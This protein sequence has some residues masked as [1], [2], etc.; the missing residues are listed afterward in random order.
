[1][2]KNFLL[3][4][5]LPSGNT[6][7]LVTEDELVSFRP[8]APSSEHKDIHEEGVGKCL[9]GQ[10]NPLVRTA[11]ITPRNPQRKAP[12]NSSRTLKEQVVRGLLN[13]L[14]A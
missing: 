3:E 10:V 11:G 2:L 4:R 13:P 1:V 12:T 7:G 6:R 8:N 14:L 5:Q 9:F